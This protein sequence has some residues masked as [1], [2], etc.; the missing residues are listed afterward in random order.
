MLAA[1]HDLAL[2]PHKVL[3]GQAA[4][5]VA[6]RAVPHLGLGAR[7]HLGTTVQIA[8]V[9]ACTATTS[10]YRLRLLTFHSIFKD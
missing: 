5:R 1:A 10:E 4:G 3:L 8:A 9:L 7:G 6:G 2:V